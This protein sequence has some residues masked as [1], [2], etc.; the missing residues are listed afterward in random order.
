MV[1]PYELKVERRYSFVPS[2]LLSVLES[3]SVESRSVEAAKEHLHQLRLLAQKTVGLNNRHQTFISHSSGSWNVQDQ[4]ASVAGFWGR[5]LL[6]LWMFAFLLGCPGGSVVKNLPP[7]QE[8]RVQSLGWDDPLEEEWQPT[9]VFLP[10][11]S[12]GQRNLAGS[13]P[14]GHKESDTTQQVSTHACMNSFLLFLY[15][16]VVC[17]R[18]RERETD[19]AERIEEACSPVSSYRALI[20][21]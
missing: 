14:R 18:N 8:T 16:V 11:E 13:S 9:P 17:V 19:K 5:H 3:R 12:H 21:S 4:G 2:R 20:P 7:V 1:P 6:G 15:L 10:G